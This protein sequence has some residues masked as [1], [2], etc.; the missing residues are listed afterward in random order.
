[1]RAISL[2]T[3][4]LIALI[5]LTGALADTWINYTAGD[6]PSMAVCEGDRYVWCGYEGGGVARFNVET[7]QK[8]IYTSADGLCGNQVHSITIDTEGAKWFGS[9]GGVSVLRSDGSWAAYPLEKDS[10]QQILIENNGSIWFRTLDSGVWHLRRDGTLTNCRPA[11]DSDRVNEIVIDEDGNKWFLMSE[12]GVWLL[13]SD[14]NWVNYGAPVSVEHM[15][16]DVDGRKWFVCHQWEYGAGYTHSVWSLLPDGTWSQYTAESS[17]LPNEW[18]RDMAID[19]DGNKWFATFEGLGIL[20][21]DGTWTQLNSENSGLADDSVEQIH[22]DADGAR[23][24]MHWGR[25]ISVLHPNGEWT[26]YNT[27]NSGFAD[28]RVTYLTTDATGRKW[29]DVFAQGVNVLDV[30]GNWTKLHGGNSGLLGDHA[31]SLAMDAS[32]TIWI[33][34]EFQGASA[35]HSDGSWATYT[36]ENSGLLHERVLSLSVAPDDSVW[37]GLRGGVSVLSSES[38]WA[39]LGQETIDEWDTV[40]VY[41]IDFEEDGAV[42]LVTWPNGVYGARPNG[43]ISL[44]TP[45]NSPIGV[46]RDLAIDLYGRKWFANEGVQVLDRNGEWT[47][48]TQENSGL[49]GEYTSCVAIDD[50]DRKWFGSSEGVSVLDDNGLWTSYSREEMGLTNDAYIWDIAFDADG[51]V[52]FATP[53]CGIRILN[54]DCSWSGFTSASSGLPTDYILSILIDNQNRKWFASLFGG[55]AVLIE[56]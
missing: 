40:E 31:S 42:W 6:Y 44:Y 52:W 15:A 19:T 9:T 22:F 21:A 38:D 29:F 25:G 20:H 32:G 1:M 54:P 41:A 24:F 56:D 36:S 17:N 46:G 26:L 16:I 30:D 50:Q 35:F 45:D 28:D 43:A 12:S 33:G 27:G 55:V 53:Y 8:E 10:I 18:V 39:G 2:T 7:W 11:S 14:G 3:A 34:H 5:G 51:R 48:Y 47:C 37:F 23:W 4:A 13:K 49:L